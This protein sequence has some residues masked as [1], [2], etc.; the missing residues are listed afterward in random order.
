MRCQRKGRVKDELK[1]SGP[2]NGMNETVIEGHGKAAAGTGRRRGIQVHACEALFIQRSFK[3]RDGRTRPLSPGRGLNQRCKAS[4]WRHLECLELQEGRAHHPSRHFT[5]KATLIQERV[6]IPLSVWSS[7]RSPASKGEQRQKRR[8]SHPSLFKPKSRSAK[9][10]QRELQG[11]R[12]E[13]SE[14]GEWVTP[15]YFENYMVLLEKEDNG[16]KQQELQSSSVQSKQA[17]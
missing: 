1:A 11:S 5:H 13:L 7:I 2:R 10:A 16:K 9:N 4:C 6:L 14:T 8:S 15:A 17:K 12:H 3:K